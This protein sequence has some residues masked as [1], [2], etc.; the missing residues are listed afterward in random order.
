MVAVENIIYNFNILMLYVISALVLYI[1]LYL[2]LHEDGD[3]SVRN[4]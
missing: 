4:M 3:L 1:P 2:D